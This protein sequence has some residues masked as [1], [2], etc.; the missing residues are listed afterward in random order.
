M[1]SLL[2]RMISA[3]QGDQMQGVF[4]LLRNA[5]HVQEVVGVESRRPH[6][7]RDGNRHG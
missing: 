4:V 6:G 5:L 3:N 2:R 7:L 1:F